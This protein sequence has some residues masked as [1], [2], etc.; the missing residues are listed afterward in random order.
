MIDPKTLVVGDRLVHLG[1]AYDVV[2]IDVFGILMQ[3]VGG[4]LKVS[5]MPEYER[6]WADA[7]KVKADIIFAALFGQHTNFALYRVP[8]FD[9]MVAY[10]WRT[11]RAHG[12]GRYYVGTEADAE[13]LLADWRE[14]GNCE[15]RRTEW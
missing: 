9:V 5:V 4:A 1:A 14:S 12:H 10:D 3:S 15:Y 8:G 2:S 6:W 7:Y 11:A 13:Q